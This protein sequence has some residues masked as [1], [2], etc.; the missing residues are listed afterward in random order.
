MPQLPEDLR[1]RGGTLLIDD[2]T[3]PTFDSHPFLPV[4]VFGSSV[5]S[6]DV[7]DR[8]R[9]R[10]PVSDNNN[11]RYS[12]RIICE[13]RQAREQPTREALSPPL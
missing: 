6:V 8:Q 4:F 11:I 10:E 2:P 3:G 5:V 12:Q 9:E 13:C 7:T 1:R